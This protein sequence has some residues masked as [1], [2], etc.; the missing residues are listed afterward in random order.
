MLYFS[1]EI[2]AKVSLNESVEMAK[3]Y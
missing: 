1:E 3:I 2:P